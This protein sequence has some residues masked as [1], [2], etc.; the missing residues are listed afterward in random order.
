MEGANE[1]STPGDESDL[2]GERCRPYPGSNNRA[3]IAT[4]HRLAPHPETSSSHA[5]GEHLP[6]GSKVRTRRG[7]A[8]AV[9]RSVSPKCWRNAGQTRGGRSSR[10]GRHLRDLTPWRCD[11]EDEDHRLALEP[12]ALLSPGVMPPDRSPRAHSQGLPLRV[13]TCSGWPI[14]SW[15]PASRP[16]S[17]PGGL[18]A[19]PDVIRIPPSGRG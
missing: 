6:L 2:S 10:G 7:K 17:H 5:A 3:P 13:D 16:S 9:V 4:V 12:H 14:S 8:C 18:S 15:S 11:E 19:S 1:A